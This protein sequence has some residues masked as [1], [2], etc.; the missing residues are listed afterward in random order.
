M[1]GVALKTLTVSF[2]EYGFNAKLNSENRFGPWFTLSNKEKQQLGSTMGPTNPQGLNRYAYVHNNPVKYVDPSGHQAIC[3]ADYSACAGARVTNKS[4][5]SVLIKG[6]I[7]LPDGTVVPDQLIRLGPG[8]SSAALGMIDVD[9]VYVD[10]VPIDGYGHGYGTK[11][12]DSD[13]VTIENDGNG[14]LTMGR[15]DR[16]P[17]FLSQWYLYKWNMQDLANPAA[18]H[19]ADMSQTRQMDWGEAARARVGAAIGVGPYRDCSKPGA[20]ALPK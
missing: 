4:D 9:E 10:G 7:V 2:N 1:D 15:R 14:E 16:I 5:H 17:G 12:G 6:D 8:E 19:G 11:L 18:I 20:C 3:A 13:N